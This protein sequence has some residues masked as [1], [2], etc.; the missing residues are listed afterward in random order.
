VNGVLRAWRVATFVLLG[1][2]VAIGALAWPHLKFD[3]STLA[4]PRLLAQHASA[5]PLSG[6]DG[7]WLGIKAVLTFAVLLGALPLAA[8]CYQFALIGR[9][10]RAHHY[11]AARPYYPRTAVV[12]PAWNEAA[13]IGPTIDR[14]LAMDYPESSL[15]V[16]VVDDAST[17][18]T[19]VV[20]KQKEREYPGRAFHLRREKGGQGKAHTLNHGLRQ[21][22]AESWAEAVLIIDADVIFEPDTLA[23]MAR[24]LA[25]PTVGAVTAYIKEGSEP[26]NYLTRFIGYE[27]ITA[28]AA[29]RRAQNV[30]GVLACLAG[31]AQLLSRD[32]LEAIGGQIDT[33]SLA[34][35][36]FTT[37]NTQRGGRRALFDGNATVWAEE[38]PDIL[39]LWKQ[40]LRWARGN[41][42]VTLRFWHIWFRPDRDARLGGVGFGFLWFAIF[43]MPVLI[44]AACAGLVAL[45]FIDF[46]LSWVLFRLFWNFH[47]VTYLFVTLF[48]LLIDLPTAR[49]TWVQGFL[50]PGALS[51]AIIVYSC[52]P[53]LFEIPGRM[54]LS[55][56][57]VDTQVVLMRSL[58]LFI[59][60]WLGLSML[61]ACGAK[62]VDAKTS[63]RG[64]AMA[65]IYVAGYG[66]LLC[67]ITLASYVYELRGAEMKWDK[68]NKV[69]T[70]SATGYRK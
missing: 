27:Y 18:D 63:R 21:I 23:K 10:R 50:F 43:L 60:A 13:V 3:G 48:S 28:Q 39:G 67:A 29:S 37:F 14:L 47:A 12:V 54:A 66:P 65:G 46:P 69:G 4:L 30:L 58:I 44:L 59:Y 19:P 17:D 53:P 45:F 42:Q 49:R 2:F 68:T 64:L 25:D 70:V 35:D 51:L 5:A 62:V 15:R 56:L 33:S 55:L 11:E 34:E 31:G 22:L 9:H 38:P 52:V 61:A 6:H 26:G 7:I 36:T 57:A 16:Y 8:S 32:N 41:V 24:H 1:A 40:R 20:V